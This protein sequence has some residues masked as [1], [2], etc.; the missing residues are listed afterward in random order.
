MLCPAMLGEAGCA[1]A[2]P[3]RR[4]VPPLVGRSKSALACSTRSTVSK[5]TSAAQPNVRPVPTSTCTEHGCSGSAASC[6]LQGCAA[7]TLSMAA[8]RAC[9]SRSTDVARCGARCASDAHTA[10]VRW[11]S[12]AAQ[13]SACCCCFAARSSCATCDAWAACSSLW[14][15]AMANASR[16]ANLLAGDAG[17]CGLVNPVACSGLELRLGD[18]KLRRRRT[19]ASV[20]SDSAARPCVARA[21][22]SW[23]LS[24]RSE[25]LG[26]PRPTGDLASAL[27]VALCGKPLA[28]RA[29]DRLGMLGGSWLASAPDLGERWRACRDSAS[30]R[31]R[32]ASTT[33]VC[34]VSARCRPSL[35]SPRRRP[36]AAEGCAPAG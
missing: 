12:H 8:S 30:S 23:T 3:A 26:A 17:L 31:R 5:S 29:A 1:L 21:S 9:S 15:E 11:A 7:D 35:G 25:P 14:A 18:C 36:R 13:A 16:T 33:V 27:A 6:A 24:G 32:W 22:C 2:S 34:R 19:L 28:L 10:R 4:G 20:S